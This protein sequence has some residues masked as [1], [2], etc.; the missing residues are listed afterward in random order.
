MA[1]KIGPAPSAGQWISIGLCFALNWLDQSGG[2]FMSA[3][4][5]KSDKHEAGRASEE[6]R[7]DLRMKRSGAA[8]S[9]Y[10]PPT[11]E[12]IHD[13]R[14]DHSTATGPGL[15][16]ADE[17]VRRDGEDIPGPIDSLS[18]KLEEGTEEDAEGRRSA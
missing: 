17:G 6:E 5:P 15:I 2:F 11:E 4:R 10:H 9:G 12:D 16:N 1:A 7:D 18:G 3:K 14:K 13:L 8:E